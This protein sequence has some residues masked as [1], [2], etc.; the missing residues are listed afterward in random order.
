MEN[1]TKFNVLRTD[2]VTDRDSQKRK[3]TFVVSDETVNR[4]G[5]KVM[6]SGWD[7]KNFKKNPVVLINHDSGIAH[8]AGKATRVWV[9][10]KDKQ[11]MANVEFVPEGI[12]P[13]ADLAHALYDNDFLNSVSPGYLVDYEKAEFGKDE[14]DPKITFNGQ[15]LLE[16]SLATLPANPG[17]LRTAEYVINALE[18]GIIDEDLITKVEASLKVEDPIA[19]DKAVEKDTQE[20]DNIPEQTINTDYLD[21]DVQEESISESDDPY[22]SFYAAFDAIIQEQKDGKDPDKVAGKIIESIESDEDNDNDSDDDFDSYL[23]GFLANK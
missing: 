21:P 9:N 8:V 10:K 20:T 5:H 2:A 4:Y 17:A 16:I 15:E 14:K 22:E 11:L 12:S 3:M 19:D 18:L 13:E 7:L 1:Q 23:D 6:V